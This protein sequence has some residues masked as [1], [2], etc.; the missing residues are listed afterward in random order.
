MKRFVIYR[1]DPNDPSS[2]P[3]VKSGHCQDRMFELWAEQVKPL[4]MIEGVGR[5]D[6]HRVENGRIVKIPK[7]QR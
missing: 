4:V 5:D 1:P 3:I 6:T 2:G 7:E